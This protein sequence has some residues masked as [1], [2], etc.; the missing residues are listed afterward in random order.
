MNYEVNYDG[1]YDLGEFVRIKDEDIKK[2]YND[3]ERLVR[4]IPEDKTWD[5]VDYRNYLAKTIEHLQGERRAELQLEN[6]S[7]LL[8][9]LAEFYAG[10][11]Q[12]WGNAMQKTVKNAK[13]EKGSKINIERKDT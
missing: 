13:L 11:D 5:G 6:L 1:L 12:D 7:T 2:I 9:N 10:N 3:I 8:V 4:S